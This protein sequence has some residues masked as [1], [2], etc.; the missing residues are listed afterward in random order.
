MSQPDPG[1]RLLITGASGLLGS[2]L[3]RLVHNRRLAPGWQYPGRFQVIGVM[4]GEQAV[5]AAS[6]AGIDGHPPFETVLA[7]LCRPGEVERVLDLARPDAVIHCAAM[8]DV[9][10][11]E[12]YP[13]EAA[14]INADLPGRLAGAAARSAIQFLHISTDSVFDGEIQGPGVAAGSTSLPVSGSKYCEEDSPRPVNT[15]SHTKLE[16]ERKVAEAYPEALIARVNFYGWSWSGRRSL[17]EWFFLNLEQGRPIH[18]FTDLVF[19]PLLANDLVEILLRMLELRL[20][21]LYH[22]VSSESQS[23]F[24]F[25]RMLAREFGYDENLISPAPSTSAG[26]KAARSRNLV[27]SCARLENALGIKMPGQ[28]EAVRRFVELYRQGYPQGLQA[29]FTEPTQPAGN[30]HPALPS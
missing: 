25:G 11:C 3:I 10:R 13:E 28:V 26:M 14:R 19:C 30:L 17:A 9:D 20:H 7:D 16:G 27:L 6:Q 24:A 2:N 29:M 15:Y 21:G 8:T 22:V 1:F 4:R 12:T 18:G 5:P 23:K